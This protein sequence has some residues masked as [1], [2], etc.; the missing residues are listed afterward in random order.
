MKYLTAV[1]CLLSLTLPFKAQETTVGEPKKN[2]FEII[3]SRDSISGGSVTVHQDKRIERI[4][5]ENTV[6]SGAISHGYR[7]QVFSS[8]TQRTAREEAFSLER[9]LKESFPDM[10]IYVTYSSPFWK[11][12]IGNFQTTEE[13]KSFTDELLYLF[14]RL[15]STTYTVRDRIII[16]GK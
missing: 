14:P 15:K 9:R 6:G 4:V 8:N 10:G 1:L 13:A 16:T 11:V 3:S 5:A 7:V 12:R 2:A